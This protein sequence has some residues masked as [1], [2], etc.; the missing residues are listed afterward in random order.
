MK[1]LFKEDTHYKTVANL[2]IIS[3]T[4]LL[5]I[6]A[7]T[8]SFISNNYHPVYAAAKNGTKTTSSSY[9]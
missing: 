3:V 7:G 1:D 5:M 2:S 8:A 9:L 6:F 4:T